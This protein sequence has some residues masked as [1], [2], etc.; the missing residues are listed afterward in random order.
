[1]LDGIAM[2]FNYNALDSFEFETLAR[3]V[4]EIVTGVK[5]S[6][7]TAGA[8]GGVDASDFY[9]Q[10]CQQSR[11][12]MQAKHWLRRVTPKQWEDL[13]GS[14]V[15]QLKKLNKVPSDKLVIVTSAG[16]TENV[17]HKMIDTAESLGVSCCIVIDRIKLDDMLAREECKPIL[18]RH[19]KLW[20]AGTN[21]LN[22]MLNRSIDVDTEVFLNQIYE[23]E[24]LYTQTSV[25]DKAIQSL[26]Q[27]STLLIVGDPGT[28]KSVLTQMIALQLIKAD[29]KIIYSSCNNID[30]IKNAIEDNC[31]NT[32]F[33]LDDFLG[34]RCLDIDSSK[35][36][37]LVA[38]LRYTSKL[39]SCYT[40][41]NSRISIL[42][43]AKRI[44][45]PFK[46]FIDSMRAGVVIID[47][48]EM[49]LLDKARIMLANLSFENVPVEY[50]DSLR[51]RS[52]SYFSFQ[53]KCI[54]ICK[55]NNFNP[56]IIEFCCR[57]EFWKN[58]APSEFP[59]TIKEKLDHPNDVLQNEFEE[60]L[61]KPERILAYQLFS[62][63]DNSVPLSSLHSAY[64]ERLS[65]EPQ[66]DYSVNTFEK[67]LKRLQETVVRTVYI[68]NEP[69]ISMGNPSVNDYCAW[70]LANNNLEAIAMVKTI[71]FVEQLERI[72]S[73]NHCP[74]VVSTLRNA[75]ITG[76]I[77]DLP[78]AD[79]KLRPYELPGFKAISSCEE[80][81]LDSDYGWV[82]DFI[83][84]ALESPTQK[85]WE[86][87]ASYLFGKSHEWGIL[88]SR[89][90]M[91]L[92]RTRSL[93][94]N[95]L[96]GMTYI[97]APRLLEAVASNIAI[98]QNENQEDIEDDIYF[99][100]K[101]WFCDYAIDYFD[102]NF[103]YEHSIGICKRFGPF[104]DEDDWENLIRNEIEKQ[105]KT[106]FD[107]TTIKE[108]FID[109]LDADIASILLVENYSEEMDDAIDNYIWNLD[110]PDQESIFEPYSKLVQPS[111]ETHENLIVEKLFNEYHLLAD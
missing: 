20:I 47:T 50:V 86:L 59:D 44:D 69:Y 57:E 70:F 5:L 80:V 4:T 8:D 62:L 45:D 75:F 18:K 100:N 95:L 38:L 21:V 17:Q 24:G 27:N 63:G 82:A 71:V 26:R 68:K 12:V 73:V 46:K 15:K 76:Q 35:M 14:L 105:L 88:E 25:F 23:H 36:R 34:Q 41:L 53:M 110:I 78:F 93:L 84:N 7:C 22:L 43:E 83:K 97:N 56:R 42:N 16:V 1:M 11:V 79:N 52:Q 107:E 90:I 29:F 40:V 108:H 77:Y 30:R 13:V 54:D 89:Q 99:R 74:E 6:C 33:V 67:A 109:Y 60:R 61:E 2:G 85:A 51:K 31:K 9:Y 94:R 104:D 91:E 102:D 66:A 111:D 28:G 10:K 58:K 48:T 49:S 103:D 106:E 19:F 64:E 3:D 98:E 39:K 65:L 32:L 101:D 96:A 92:L 37:E 55:H 87:A 81:L 72:T